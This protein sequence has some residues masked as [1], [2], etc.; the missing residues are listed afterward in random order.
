MEPSEGPKCEVGDWVWYLR[1]RLVLGA[2]MQSWWQGP[3]RVLAQCGER[4]FRLRTPQGDE[5]E[6]HLDQLKPCVWEDLG[7]PEGEFHYPPPTGQEGS[8]EGAR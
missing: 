3:F 6:C 2:K 8:S 5:F 7:T 1:P 4:S